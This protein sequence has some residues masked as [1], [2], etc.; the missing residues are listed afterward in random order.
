MKQRHSLLL[1]LALLVLVGAIW[2]YILVAL[3]SQATLD[4]R[5][6]DVGEQLKCPVCQNES[7]ADSAASIAEQMRL[8]IRQQLQ[9][10]KSE[11]QVLG[12]FADHY[13][14]QILL[15]PPQQ[16]FNLL[17]WLMPVALLLLG[18]GLVTL[19]ARGWRAQDPLRT[20]RVTGQE[21]T[22][23]QLD[24]ELEGYRLQ[25][26]QELADEDPLMEIQ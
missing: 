26:E 23:S 22:E 7:V 14:K 8:V 10:G 3:P 4:Q 12:Y 18:L 25:L 6:H 5:V 9:A 1:L 17:A 19:V 21:N 20:T 15:T 24:P 11:Q 2:S 16:G 13:G